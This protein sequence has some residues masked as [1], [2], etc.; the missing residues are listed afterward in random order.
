MAEFVGYECAEGAFTSGGMISNLTGILV[1][2][3]RALPGC[4]RR[5]LRRA[6]GRRLLLGRGAP[7]GR[8]GGRGRRDRLRLRAPARPGRARRMRPA[9][10]RRG[11]RRRPRRR[12]R[13]RS[14]SSPT[15]APRSPAPSTRS[16]ELADVCE[17]HGVWLHVDGAY[18]LPAAATETR[19]PAVRRARARRLGHPRRP[20]VARAAEE[21]Q[22]DPGPRSRARSRR[23]SA[24]RS[25]TC[26]AA[27]RSCATRSSR[28][29]STRGRCAR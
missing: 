10:A 3:E 5:G 17:R 19:R 18:G 29:S 27:T 25:P 28:R 14:P 11:A 22:P 6:P 12:G 13:C 7:L 9:D 24:T 8:P 15:A 16:T 2:R 21:L 1:A 23:P 26:T 4:R 20:Q